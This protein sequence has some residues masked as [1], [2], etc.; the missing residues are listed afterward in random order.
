MQLIS[1]EFLP[2]PTISAHAGAITYFQ[3]RKIAAWFGGDVEGAC[4]TDIYTLQDGIGIPTPLQVNFNN[5]PAWNPVFVQVAKRLFL[6]FKV[7]KF[8]DSWQTFY[9][10]YKDG[11]FDRAG[12]GSLP[13][14]LNGPVKTPPVIAGKNMIFFGSSVETWRSWASYIEVFEFKKDKF[15]F[16]ERSQPILLPQDDKGGGLIQPAL[17]ADKRGDI[18]AFFRSKFTCQIWYGTDRNQF[19]TLKPLCPGPNSSVAAVWH[20]DFIYLA[21]NPSP[22]SRM[23]LDILKMSMTKDGPSILD[24]FVVESDLDMTL[25]EVKEKAVMHPSGQFN[26]IIGTTEEFSYPY[27]IVNPDNNLE[28]VYTYGRRG[29]KRAVV[30]VS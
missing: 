15:K 12:M 24:S 1:N 28:L 11:Q 27:M 16:L 26:R 20:D 21:C 22:D 18:H 9:M 6:F 23:P 3:G 10:E 30:S 5:F 14:G 8:C 25:Y 2:V 19:K 4:N 29:I 7:G 13:A 17:V